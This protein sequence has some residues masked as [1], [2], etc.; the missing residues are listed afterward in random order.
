M[1]LVKNPTYFGNA[2]VDTFDIQYIPD[3]AQRMNA[4]LAGNLDLSI[5]QSDDEVGQAVDAKMTVQ[6]LS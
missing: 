2:N 1:T 3:K 5:S 6:P 4:F